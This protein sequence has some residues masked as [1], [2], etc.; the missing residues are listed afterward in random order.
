[1]IEKYELYLQL[2]GAKLDKFFTKQKPYIKCKPGCSFCCED[3]QYPYSQLEFNYLMVGF[4]KLPEDIKQLI[5]EKIQKIK[6][7]QSEFK[8]DTFYYECPF[9]INKFCSVYH[10]RGIICRTHGLPY[11][12]DDNERIKIPACTLKGLNYADVYDKEAK[13]FTTEKFKAT[14]YDVEPLSFNLSLKF[15]LCPE[16]EE[17]LGIKF[18]ESKALIERL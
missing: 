14:G 16:I 5:K 17:S 4:E 10:Y 6:K 8:G 7:E 12:V 18:G 1:M 13:T 3:G 11:F 9:L 2:L 15:L